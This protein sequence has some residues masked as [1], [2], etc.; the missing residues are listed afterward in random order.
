M[1][2]QAIKSSLTDFEKW[3]NLMQYGCKIFF[4]ALTKKVVNIYRVD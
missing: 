2:N 3:D 4:N 1:V